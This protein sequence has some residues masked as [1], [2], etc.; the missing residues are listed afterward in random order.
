M[1]TLTYMP[2]WRFYTIS[3]SSVCVCVLLCVCV[4]A[5][6]R[7]CVRAGVRRVRV[8]VSG[9]V[10]EFVC[11]CVHVRTCLYISLRQ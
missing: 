8:F 7:M 3:S 6:V 4:C 10:R 1:E 9:F 11:V 5:R 2:I